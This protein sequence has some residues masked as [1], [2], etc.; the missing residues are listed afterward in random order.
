M[1]WDCIL[2]R[3]IYP[4]CAWCKLRKSDTY[5]ITT[6]SKYYGKYICKVCYETKLT[7][8]VSCIP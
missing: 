7:A 6:W 8:R 3:V 1:C 4:K 2:N 5:K